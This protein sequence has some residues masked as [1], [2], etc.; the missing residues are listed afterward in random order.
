MLENF[1]FLF[2]EAMR[3][4]GAMPHGLESTHQLTKELTF[5]SLMP[6]GFFII[7]TQKEKKLGTIL[8]SLIFIKI[9]I[10]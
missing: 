9:S 5:L 7:S 4:L 2:F 10:S 1:A 8:L 6:L 3:E